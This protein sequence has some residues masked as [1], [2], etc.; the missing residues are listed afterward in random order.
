MKDTVRAAILNLYGGSFTRGWGY[1][2]LF[3]GTIDNIVVGVVIATYNARFNNYSLN[4]KE[5]MHLLAVLDSG[6]IGEAYVVTTKGRVCVDAAEARKMWER[7]KD[8]EPINGVYGEFWAIPG[9]S[10]DNDP[11]AVSPM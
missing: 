8:V 1:K 4:K 2:W 3:F 6:K 5:F 7:L 11:F 10:D 9:L